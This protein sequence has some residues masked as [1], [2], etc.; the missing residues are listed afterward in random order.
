M[1]GYQTS[2]RPSH[3]CFTEFDTVQTFA[4]DPES[5]QKVICRPANMAAVNTNPLTHLIS[6]LTKLSGANGGLSETIRPSLMKL[7]W[8]TG[9]ENLG[10]HHDLLSVPK[11]FGQGLR[12][13]P[14]FDG[15]ITETDSSAFK[16]GPSYTN[17][18]WHFSS[19]CRNRSV[20]L[21]IWII[22]LI[23]YYLSQQIMCMHRS[24][25]LTYSSIKSIKIHL[26]LK[27]V[28]SRSTV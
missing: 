20:V 17:G 9:A 13:P 25:S 24:L 15:R 26:K 6:V 8:I 3:V 28:S 4:G 27:C 5:R 18:L 10:L 21:I 16:T 22:K 12:T 23:L 2:H 7:T 1:C 19:A 11:P 14:S